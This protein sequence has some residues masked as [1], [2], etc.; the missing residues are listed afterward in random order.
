MIGIYK[1]TSPSERVYIGQSI[2]IENRFNEY[3]NLKNCKGQTRLYNSLKKYGIENHIFEIVTLCYEEQLNEFE[4]DFQEA[5]DV[6]GPMGMNC[7]LI[8]TKDRATK[9]SED[10]KIKISNTLKGRIFSES[11]LLKMKQTQL[12]EKHWN[13]GKKVPE[14]RKEKISLKLK[15]ENNH[16]YNKEFSKETKDKMS[17]SH[18]K[19]KQVVNIV[20]NIIYHSIKEASLKENINYSILVQ[21][22]RGVIKN[23]TN[24]IY[25]NDQR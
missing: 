20:N 21:Q 25:Y 22:L 14:E 11:T 3:Y 8:G 19:R 15:G 5:Y 2:D 1:I 17:K 13:Y 23:T 4:R 24:L 12:G 16:N 10:S 6:I 18:H 9:H 7:K